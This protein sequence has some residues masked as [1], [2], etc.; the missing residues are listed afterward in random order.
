MNLRPHKEFDKAGVDNFRAG[1]AEK[2]GRRH[3]AGD[4]DLQHLR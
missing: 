2:A 1:S 4:E 3:L